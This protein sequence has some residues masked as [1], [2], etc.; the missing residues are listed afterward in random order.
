MFYGSEIL[1][2][3]P[4][5]FLL[6]PIF[7]ESLSIAPK[8]EPRAFPSKNIMSPPALVIAREHA[9]THQNKRHQET[10]RELSPGSAFPLELS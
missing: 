6:I 5:P 7:G 3:E 9:I 1:S 4:S 10:R 8:R 2:R